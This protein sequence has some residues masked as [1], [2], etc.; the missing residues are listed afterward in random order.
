M[1]CAGDASLTCGGPW[2]MQIYATGL[3]P[4]GGQAPAGWASYGCVRDSSDRVLAAPKFAGADLSTT[5]SPAACMAYCARA[6]YTMAGLEYGACFP[7]VL[8]DGFIG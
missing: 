8:R 7:P 2:R 4:A 6:N 5:N 1:P 3:Q